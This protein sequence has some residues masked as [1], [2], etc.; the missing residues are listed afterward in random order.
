MKSTIIGVGGVRCSVDNRAGGYEGV[1]LRVHDSQ[2]NSSTFVQLD[3]H[4]AQAL[5]D[6]IYLLLGKP[7]VI[8]VPIIASGTNWHDVNEVARGNA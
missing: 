4:G 7:T 1:S 2:F 8:T 5:A 3:A 6:S